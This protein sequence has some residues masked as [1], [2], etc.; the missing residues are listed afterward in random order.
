MKKRKSISLLILVFSSLV[1]GQSY[2]Q[3]DQDAC[4][5]ALGFGE[6]LRN[7]YTH[8]ENLLKDPSI[9][10]LEKI[11]LSYNKL[12]R[13]GMTVPNTALHV[14]AQSE[15]ILSVFRLV[16][17]GIPVDVPGR[18]MG[19]TP[20]SFAAEFGRINTIDALLELGADINAPDILGNSSLHY[21]AKKKNNVDAVK[22]LL[23]RGAGVDQ[24]DL[25]GK[26]PIMTAAM[27]G[28]EDIFHA[29]ISY[30]A[31][32]AVVDVTG[33]TILHRVIISSKVENRVKMM[34]LIL[35]NITS[36]PESEGIIDW[37][38]SV[39]GHT[40]LHWAAYYGHTDAIAVLLKRG[41]SLI[42]KNKNGELPIHV[43]ARS[44]QVE[45][46]LMLKNANPDLLTAVDNEGRSPMEAAY[47]HS[48]QNVLSALGL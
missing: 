20:L 32:L 14:T 33:R 7:F 2:A 27:Y 24:T 17:H 30:G 43:A 48:S 35:D 38:D 22:H 39:Y 4:A 15:D 11:N 45:A 31:S 46:F 28:Y 10:H 19:R 34:E 40:P 13:K 37:P 16:H 26:T 29:L 18:F 6:D 47:E 42:T 36:W 23:E 41:T 44:D 21:A 5:E 25:Y 3:I 9:E 12:L 1:S 8:R